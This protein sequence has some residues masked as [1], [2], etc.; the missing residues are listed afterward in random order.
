MACSRTRDE[1]FQVRDHDADHVVVR[2]S[3][4]LETGGRVLRRK[5]CFCNCALAALIWVS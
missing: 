5:T 3:N 4:D 2:L 1:L